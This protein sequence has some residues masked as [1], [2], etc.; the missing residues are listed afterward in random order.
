MEV[1]ES[2]QPTVK[3]KATYK[4]SYETKNG[5]ADDRAPL[6]DIEPIFQDMLL[7]SCR[8]GPDFKGDLEDF[9]REQW[10]EQ[11][12]RKSDTL[13]DLNERLKSRPITMATMCSGTEAPLLAVQL[14]SRSK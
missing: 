3:K 13:M 2:G 6:E 4:D 5:I 9:V 11:L 14:F 8:P 1:D 10:A 12:E 7:R